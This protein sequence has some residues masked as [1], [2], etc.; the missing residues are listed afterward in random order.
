MPPRPTIKKNN[1][2]SM[3]SWKSL[4]TSC[5]APSII[6]LAACVLALFVPRVIHHGGQTTTIFPQIA[7]T[8][9][10]TQ[11]ADSGYQNHKEEIFAAAATGSSQ[12]VSDLLKLGVKSNIR[13][14]KLWTPL[15]H[16]AANGNEETTKLLLKHKK[17]GWYAEND[18]T[19]LHLAARHG[20]TNAARQILKISGHN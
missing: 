11:T 18:T 14:P 17:M 19:P 1:L 9:R 15:H 10:S 7:Q 2:G 20:H 16:A 5:W 4:F 13:D 12:D 3:P 8:S 6:C